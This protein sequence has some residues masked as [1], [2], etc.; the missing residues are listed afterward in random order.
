MQ[1][2][3]RDGSKGGASHETTTSM[4]TSQPWRWTALSTGASQNCQPATAN[5]QAAAA[6]Q[7]ASLHGSAAGGVAG[8]LAAAGAAGSANQ[9][10]ATQAGL[11]Y[12]AQVNNFFSF[13]NIFY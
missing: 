5:Q 10:L 13:L 3:T 11:N 4:G 2:P 8:Q 1:S 7:A 6:V 9:H 12:A